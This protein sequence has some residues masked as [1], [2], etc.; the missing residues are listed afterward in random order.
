[1]P[2]SP[3]ARTFYHPD[4]AGKIL[5]PATWRELEWLVRRSPMAVIVKG[6]LRGDDAVR[7]VECGARAIIV[8]NH[9][10]R[11]LDTTV[12]TAAAI[13]EVASVLSGNAEVYVD[14][15]IRRGTDILKALALGARAVMIGRPV[16]WALSVRGSDGVSEVLEHL[17]VELV[18]A[19]QLSG[20]AKLKDITRDF[21]APR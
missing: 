5:Y 18:R 20:A 19:M 4:F 16:L 2:G 17:R 6:V 3:M 11:H 10:G 21:L 13:G 7:C 14:G 12:T 8:S 1:M 15:G 9:G